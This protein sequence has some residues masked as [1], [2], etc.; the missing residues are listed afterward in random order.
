MKKSCS[1]TGKSRL[2]KGNINRALQLWSQVVGKSP[3][4]AAAT[5]AQGYLTQYAHDNN[6]FAPGG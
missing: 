2:L 4:S 3:G 6:P 5:E 1:K